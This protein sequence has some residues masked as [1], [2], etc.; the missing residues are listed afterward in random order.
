MGLAEIVEKAKN[1]QASWNVFQEACRGSQT[2]SEL[3]L[4]RRFGFLYRT[5]NL[6][7]G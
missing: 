6:I 7:G 4:I 5:T 3:V 2:D 1:K